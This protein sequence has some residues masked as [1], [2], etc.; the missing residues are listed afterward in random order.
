MRDEERDCSSVE[1]NG[2]LQIQPLITYPSAPSLP[3]SR[4]PCRRL[5]RD[6]GRDLQVLRHLHPQGEDQPGRASLDFHHP[7][8]EERKGGREGGRNALSRGEIMRHLPRTYSP[9]LPP[10]LPS[11]SPGRP[12]Q[13]ASHGHGRGL[14]QDHAGLQ[15]RLRG[16]AR[17][18]S[19]CG[20]GGRREG[21]REGGR[22]RGEGGAQGGLVSCPSFARPSPDNG[23]GGGG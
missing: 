11:L 16:R 7:C 17:L 20:N 5:R 15:D 3:P 2:V 22:E 10:S 6:P 19:L 4:P 23:P 13:G 9:S 8:K 12:P 18:N 21:G 1:T 14:P